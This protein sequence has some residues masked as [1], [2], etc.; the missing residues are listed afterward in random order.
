MEIAKS[1]RDVSGILKYLNVWGMKEGSEK[2]MPV[3]ETE[4]A[5][6]GGKWTIKYRL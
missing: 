6:V 5:K 4:Y 2:E 3:G 1:V